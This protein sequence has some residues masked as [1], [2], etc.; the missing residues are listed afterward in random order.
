MFKKAVKK[1]LNK[2]SSKWLVLSIDVTLVL[3]TFTVSYIIRFNFQPDFDGLYLFYQLPIIALISIISFLLIGSHKGIIRHTG[4]KDANNIVIGVNIIAT[5]LIV[6]VLFGRKHSFNQVFNIPLSI[7]YIHY[8]LNIVILVA[9]RFIFKELYKYFISDLKMSTNLLIYGAG[10]LGLTTYEAIK[11][12]VHNKYKVVG[13]IDDNSSKSGKNIDMV[14][15]YSFDQIDDEFIVKHNI[16][17]IVI[18]IKSIQSGRLMEITDSFISKSLKVKIVP[19]VDKW[20]DGDLQ[21]GQIKQVKIEDLL[22]RQPIDIDNPILKKEMLDKVVLITGAAGSIGS[23]IARQVATYDYKKLILL[24]QAESPLYDLQ[25]EF[26]RNNRKNFI[27]IIG[28][29]RDRK[30]IDQVFDDFKPDLVYHA[31]AYKHVPLMENNPY[32]AVRANVLGTMNVT[33]LAIKHKVG[34][35]VMVSTDK[36]VNPTNVMGSTKR[37]AELYITCLKDNPSTKFITTR[38]GNVLGSNGSVIPLF[39]KQIE[40]GGPLTVTHREIT[41]YFMTIPEAC[42]LVLEAGSIGKGGEIFV[43]DMGQ[44]IKIF[45]LAV[46]MIQLSGLKYPEDIDIKI[47]GLRPGEKIYEELLG[48]G[49]NTTKTHHEKIMIAKVKDIDCDI[50]KSK[51]IDICNSL[52]TISKTEIVSKIKD[53]VPEYISNNSEYELLDKEIINN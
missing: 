53:I 5:L 42:Q 32:Q 12:D 51:I 7:I 34:K 39:K 26:K 21:V 24:D 11:N 4:L 15:V 8:L 49:E 22:G 20:I 17:E 48:D 46:N 27:V 35:F 3:L 6:I 23:E 47:V 14:K 13:F 36:A 28:D 25:Q 37:L 38:F 43:F 2:H 19:P 30:K 52:E 9:S 31:A 29:V 1:I 16:K 40:V 45:D 44:S 50:I 41:R 33:D 10:N 18:A